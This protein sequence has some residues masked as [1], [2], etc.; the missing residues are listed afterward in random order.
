MQ[1]GWSGPGVLPRATHALVHSSKSKRRQPF[2]YEVTASASYI[3]QLTRCTLV[4]HQQS[5]FEIDANH[6]H[7]KLISS[8]SQS[9]VRRYSTAPPVPLLSRAALAQTGRVKHSRDSTC[10]ART[11][12][13]RRSRTVRSR[14]HQVL[15]LPP[16]NLCGLF[17]P[18]VT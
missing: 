17:W 1:A 11:S 9:P 10:V 3:S 18:S 15:F 13:L 5:A 16:T 12:N 4:C 2:Q 7:T 6:L 14:I 8:L